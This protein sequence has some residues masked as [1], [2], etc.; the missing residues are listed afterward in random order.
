MGQPGPRMTIKPVS[1]LGVALHCAHDWRGKAPVQSLSPAIVATACHACSGKAGRQAG[2]ADS[3]MSMRASV[4]IPRA[5]TSRASRAEPGHAR[6]IAVS[7]PDGCCNG[8]LVEHRPLRRRG[9]HGEG[10]PRERAARVPG[11][12]TR[13]CPVRLLPFPG[14]SH[15]DCVSGTA[16]AGC[17]AASGLWSVTRACF[18][19]AHPEPAPARQLP[20]R[21]TPAA[22]SRTAPPRA[23]P[24]CSARAA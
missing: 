15:I 6:I 12:C 11:P 4:C 7:A 5:Q 3:F 13:P 18:A 10:H 24:A 23:P 21:R 19:R 20:G 9:P 8:V 2:L 1:G 14:D 17:N 22:P 16:L